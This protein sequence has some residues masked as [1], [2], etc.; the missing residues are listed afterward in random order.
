MSAADKYSQ[1][2]II[3]GIHVDYGEAGAFVNG[4]GEICRFNKAAKT[5]AAGAGLTI[6]LRTGRSHTHCPSFRGTIRIR[7]NL[8]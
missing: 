1:D 4:G 7:H 2:N 3:D 5:A 8:R 6:L